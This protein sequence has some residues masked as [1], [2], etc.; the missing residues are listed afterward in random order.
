MPAKPNKTQPTA[1]SVADYLAAV[2]PD[3]RREDAL[4][5]CEMMGRLSGEPAKMWGPSMVGFGLRRYRYA[6]GH[7][8]EIFKVGFAPRKPAMVLYVVG[9]VEGDPL[10]AKLGKITHGKGCIYVKRLADIDLKVLEAMIV[11]ALK[12]GRPSD[13][14]EA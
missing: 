14:A 12:E 3:V 10:V 5:L 1:V 7:G 13:V 4:V 11:R 2:E 6:S 8:G 9:W